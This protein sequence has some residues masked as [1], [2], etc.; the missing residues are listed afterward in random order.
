MPERQQDLRGEYRIL[1]RCREVRGVPEPL[2]VVAGAERQIL[3][4][5]QLPGEPLSQ[6]EVSWPRF[7]LIMARLCRL[8]LQLA[9]RGV[10]HNDLSP[11]NILV[12]PGSVYL[13]DF[14]QA[15][16]GTFGECL[17]AALG[18][19]VR[20]VAVCNGLAAPLRERLQERLSPRVIRAVRG[21][22]LARGGSQTAP[23]PL[24]PANPGPALCALSEAWRIA[25]DAG[26]TSPGRRIA[27]Y[28]L[29]YENVRFP[30]E[31]SWTARWRSLR[32]ITRYAGRRVLELGCN[33]ALLSTFALREGGACAALAVDRDPAVLAAAA[34]VAEAFGVAPELRPVDFDRDQDWEDRLAAFRPDLV[35]ALSVL[36]WIGDQPRFLRF[37]GRFDEVIFE[38][39]DSARRE[40]RRLRDAGF[41]AIDLVGTSE[42]G[43]ALFVARRHEPHALPST[44][45]R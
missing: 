36:H 23:L 28:E 11:D 44:A 40:R 38:G 42:R 8:L 16:T 37:L 19:S 14:D 20:G 22:R 21:R 10:R 1:W 30:G 3:L 45:S 39:H 6:V 29:V 12:A 43:R 13:V 7:A 18:R 15:S 4:M 2:G 5:R 26:A 32:Y 34:K 9:R 27:Y 35:V 31:R 25:A 41:A 33:M 24:L 17:L